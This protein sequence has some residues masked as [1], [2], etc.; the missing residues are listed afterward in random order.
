MQYLRPS[1]VV[2]ENE[3]KIRPIYEYDEQKKT[4]NNV[5]VVVNLRNSITLKS[6]KSCLARGYVKIKLTFD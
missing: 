6:N 1:T 2:C 5:D 4:P 3:F